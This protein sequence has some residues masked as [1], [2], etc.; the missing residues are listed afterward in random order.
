[1]FGNRV[2][3]F[4]YLKG[5]F[6]DR[7]TVAIRQMTDLGEQM[8]GPKSPYIFFISKNA[9]TELD[10][11]AVLKVLPATKENIATVTKLISN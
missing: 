1:M 5:S 3:G 2:R 4:Q 11:F 8:P 9:Q 7:S 6:D 10:P